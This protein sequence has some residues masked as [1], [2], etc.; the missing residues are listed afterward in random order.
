MPG[1]TPSTS[2]VVNKT[3]LP[4]WV[5]DAGKANYDKA[6]SLDNAPLS[7]YTGPRVAAPSAAT[8]NAFSFFGDH[9]NDGTAD[10]SK[11]AEIFRRLSDPSSYAAG[12]QGYLNPYIDNVE[13][14]AIGALNDQLTN[15]LQNNAD[16][17]IAAKAFGGSRAAIVDGISRAQSAKDAGV[18]S[19]QLR[20]QGFDAASSNYSRDQQTAGTG[21]LQTGNDKFANMLKQFAGMRQIG[22]DTD[23]YNQ[24]VIDSDMAKFDEQK[25]K[26]LNDLNLRLSTLGMTPYNQSTSSK[27]TATAGSFGFDWGTGI[28][29][30]LSIL[31]GL[32]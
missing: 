13:T 1:P 7:Q 26:E 24:K 2:T 10:I 20:Q 22:A 28:L 30:G 4:Q 19:A 31:A 25:N 8:T 32:L 29:G 12:V 27:T 16:K 3:E 6:V 18:L 11:S 5:S 17:A 15:T 21:L 14:K 9:L 23:T